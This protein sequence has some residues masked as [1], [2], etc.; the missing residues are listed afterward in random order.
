MENADLTLTIIGRV[1]SPLKT[2]EECPRQGF[3]NAPE[4]EIE[5]FPSFL[6]G[7]DGMEPGRDIFV[8]TWLHQADRSILQVR[9]RRNPDAQLKGVFATRSPVRPNPIGLHRV[10]LLEKDGGRLLV[11]PLEAVDGT[12]VIDIKPVITR[13]DEC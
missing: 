4:A 1:S 9:P 10:K 3:E 5:I 6:E 8:F 2:R 12:P 7:L 11:A 13:N